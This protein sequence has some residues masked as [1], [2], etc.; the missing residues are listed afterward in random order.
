MSKIVYPQLFD[1]VGATGI[2]RVPYFFINGIEK[3]NRILVEPIIKEED[4]THEVIDEDTD[5]IYVVPEWMIPMIIEKIEYERMTKDWKKTNNFNGEQHE[6]LRIFELVLS[7]QGEDDL[8][9]LLKMNRLEKK[10]PEVY[11]F[12]TLY[13]KAMEKIDIDILRNEIRRIKPIFNMRGESI[14]DVEKYF[15]YE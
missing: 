4:R 10:A 13:D 12:Q 7:K 11:D 1:I 6:I 14:P 3:Y 2:D 8:V 9:E 5:T 15:S